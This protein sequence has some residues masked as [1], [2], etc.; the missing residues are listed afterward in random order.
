MGNQTSTT[1][2]NTAT[3]TTQTTYEM[4]KLPYISSAINI[5]T[6]NLQK[7]LQNYTTSN[8][9]K[10]CIQN[11]VFSAINNPS[12]N[13]NLNV[14]YYGSGR[15]NTEKIITVSQNQNSQN[16]GKLV[17]KSI[18]NSVQ[19]APSYPTSSCYENFINYDSK[20]LFCFNGTFTILT[21][22]VLILLLVYINTNSQK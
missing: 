17:S 9:N 18:S 3:A 2:Y 16:P 21:I 12:E 1:D 22:F 10:L 5:N 13:T 20:N 4:Y 19:L 11:F 8:G 15:T 14:S 7:C 6:E